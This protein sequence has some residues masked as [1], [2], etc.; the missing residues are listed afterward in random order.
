MTARKL[1][2]MRKQ[3]IS[4]NAGFTAV[5]TTPRRIARRVSSGVVVGAVGALTLASLAMP[6]HAFALPQGGQVAA[7]SAAISTSGSAQMNINQLSDRAVIN[8]QGFNINVNELVKFIQPGANSVIL[9]RVV[10]QDPSKILGQ[11]SAN[12]RVF[13][14]NPN[15]I[16]F[17]ASSKVDVAGLV[18]TTFNIN[19]AD[20]MSGKNA[21]SQDQSKALAAV[22]NRGEI[23]V[24]DNGFV[25]L[26]APAVANEGLIVAKVGSVGLA[27]GKSFTLDFYGDGDIKFAIE[28][29]VKDQV[30]DLDG[31]AITSAVSNSGTI[32]ADGGTVLLSG[33]AASD[34][35]ASVI[36]Q[37]GIVEAKG[38]G[39][40]AA[41]SV[42]LAA[43]G[44]DTVMSGS[45]DVSG[46]A[47]NADGGTAKVLAMDGTADFSGTILARGGDAGG[48][49]GS[50]EVSGKK[51]AIGGVVNTM[52]P[53]GKTGTFLID[54]NDIEVNTSLT[55][56]GWTLITPTTI[57]TNL[58]TTNLTLST[59]AETGTASAGQDIEVNAALSYSGANTLRLEAGEDIRVQ[60]DITMASGV[61][62]LIAGVRTDISSGG[63]SQTSGAIDVATLTAQA[64]GTI[65][66]NSVTAPTL[67][68]TI[69]TGANGLIS[70]SGW[71][72][73]SLT[74]ATNNKSI[75]VT[76]S[77]GSIAVVDVNA[78]TA[79]A[80]LTATNGAIT[81]SVNDT[82]T[83]ITAGNVLLSASTGIGTTSP[84]DVD[85]PTITS[86]TTATGGISLSSN[87][88]GNV[89]F[90]TVTTSGAGNIT[91]AAAVGATLTNVTTANGAIT[92]TAAG[93]V[94]ATNVVSSTDLDANDILISTTLGNIEVDNINAGST[95]GDVTLTANTAV[96]QAV[97]DSNAN[98]LITADVVTINVE[99]AIGGAANK[100]NTTAVT[101]AATSTNSGDIY[102]NETNGLIIGATSTTVGAVNITAA[103]A[104][105]TS[106]DITG[107]GG[108]VSITGV[109]VTNSNII[110]GDTNGVT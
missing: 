43:K 49:G 86:A 56:T 73:G 9:N 36:N 75:A 84:L 66:L 45:L 4:R 47:G 106:G 57:E 3:R 23:K 82:A 24:A 76:A 94:T 19:N 107:A 38:F 13:L 68:T 15:G 11:M 54:P 83:K 104:I 59:A 72:G 25:Y 92:V 58:A 41:G 77:L 97:T 79:Q 6:N 78:G 105:T 42:T 60:S 32:K 98:S 96:G 81:E 53:N 18:A 29:A 99:G 62:E 28:G 46:G 80:S 26:V 61:L 20:F 33:S 90:S 51:V 74:A 48:N 71:Q 65:S 55:Q 2:R 110:T 40:T 16:L 88:A 14:T 108:A 64:D 101:V 34:V 27:S 37:S 7:G 1:S 44:G 69:N 50:V 8:W 87:Q 5:L 52:A 17:G 30:K 103:G 39:G 102:I 22:R 100:I 63:V 21:F 91:L 93:T 31:K 70:V 95:A 89:T 67:T 12:G 10:G 35:F 85:S 109:G